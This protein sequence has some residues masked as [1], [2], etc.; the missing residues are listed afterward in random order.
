MSPCSSPQIPH[1][2]SF[3]EDS[4]NRL[5]EDPLLLMMTRLWYGRTC[6][7]ILLTGGIL[8]DSKAEASSTSDAA[9]ALS[10]EAK[11]HK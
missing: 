7:V 4:V 2:S 1:A 8:E 6:P 11:N 3:K 5:D 10:L 9:A